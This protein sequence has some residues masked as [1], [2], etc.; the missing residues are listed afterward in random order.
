[1]EKKPEQVI[2]LKISDDLKKA[3]VKPGVITL[4]KHKPIGIEIQ[5]EEYTKELIDKDQTI[6]RFIIEYAYNFNMS[7]YEALTEIETNLYYRLES[8][9][10]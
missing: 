2:K 6:D 10:K 8:F 9:K 1:M 3:I 7:V 5:P 4:L